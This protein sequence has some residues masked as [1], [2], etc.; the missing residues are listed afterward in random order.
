MTI[1]RNS[2]R[3]STPKSSYTRCL[4]EE[5][6]LVRN[7]LECMTPEL[8]RIFCD[9]QAGVLKH[10][11]AGLSAMY[12]GHQDLPII[13]CVFHELERS[14]APMKVF[15]GPGKGRKPVYSLPLDDTPRA[16]LNVIEN[17]HYGKRLR[18][19]LTYTLREILGAARRAEIPEVL[20]RRSLS[21]Y[22]AE[23]DRRGICAKSM[24]GKIFNIKCLG[25]LFML[26]NE[27]MTV[28]NN[29][30]RSTKLEVGIEPSQRHAAFRENPLSPLD[31]ARL[32]RVASEEAYATKGNRQT[33]QRLFITAAALAL[34]SFLPE[35]ISDILGMVVGENV[36]R[37]P[38]GWSSEY[39]SRKTDVDRSFPYLPDQLTP[40]LDDL[41]LL[42]AQP[43]PQGRDFA[44][45]YHHRV[46]IQ[47]PLFVRINLHRAYSRNRIGELVKERTGHGPHAARKAMVDYLAEIGG[48]PIDVLDL[49]G[50][51]RIAT[52]EA[53]YSVRAT[54]IKRKKTLGIIDDYRAQ[55]TN[56]KTFRL[57]TGRL[58]DLDK[59]ARDLD[60]A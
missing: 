49:L 14:R 9:G 31:Y 38:L 32:A 21:A 58:I 3:A 44:N 29:E 4:V 24:E 13:F 26:D 19:D 39:F 18:H 55:L 41:I 51:K 46:K 43:G 17:S 7:Q 45:L 5:Y 2:S 47:S 10:I 42:G 50:H 48:E 16:L 35:R 20:D 60:R 37:D 56:S 54:A 6:L 30:L 25:T 23:L 33:V 53:H 12:P 59:I 11:G 28:V 34:L 57:P 8:L 1:K 15:D 52:S 40:Y 36:T 27:T 22:R